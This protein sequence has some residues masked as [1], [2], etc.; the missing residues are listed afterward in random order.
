ME[1][2]TVL[3]VNIDE[4]NLLVIQNLIIQTE[5][6][7]EQMYI[8]VGDKS[9]DFQIIDDDLCAFKTDIDV[10]TA[11]WRLLAQYFIND[12]VEKIEETDEFIVNATYDTKY[13][14]IWGW[15][16][17]PNPRSEIVK[18]FLNNLPENLQFLKK[19]YIKFNDPM[20][21]S[22]LFAYL[23][24]EMN[25]TYIH[26]VQVNNKFSAFGLTEVDWKMQPD[27]AIEQKLKEKKTE[28]YNQFV[29][30]KTKPQTV[31]W[32]KLINMYKE[33]YA[34]KKE[35]NLQTDL[36]QLRKDLGK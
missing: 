27:P 7:K 18:E 4:E 36:E 5:K 21:C 24:Q 34:E 22:Y 16:L 3:P 11:Q 14:W 6:F 15:S 12:E 20:L 31:D 2:E 17:V 33:M 26:V 23:M 25:F 13:N 1:E 30:D 19:P 9:T 32:E 35:P 29:K 10:C 28:E 8:R